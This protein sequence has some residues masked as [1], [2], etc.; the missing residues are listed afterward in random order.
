MGSLKD[1]LKPNVDLSSS[2][3]ET[4]TGSAL[5]T[6]VTSTDKLGNFILGISVI[7]AAFYLAWA[8]FKLSSSADNE[9]ER[10]KAIQQIFS[11]GIAISLLGG[12][13]TVIWFFSVFLSS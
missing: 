6:V 2:T 8:I 9:Q 11:A 3:I 13:S 7:V 4:G 5:D 10:K 1:I 12:L